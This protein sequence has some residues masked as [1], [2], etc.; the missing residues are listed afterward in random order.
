MADI[1]NVTHKGKAIFNFPAFK[2]NFEMLG[3]DLTGEV[4]I[5]LHEFRPWNK[6][7]I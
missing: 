7:Y 4:E 2:W 6:T 3:E 1:S 5:E